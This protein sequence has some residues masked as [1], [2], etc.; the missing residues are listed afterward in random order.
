MAGKGVTRSGQANRRPTGPRTRAK[1]RAA[2]GLDSEELDRQETC[3]QQSGPQSENQ[4]EPSERTPELEAPRESNEVVEDQDPL[5]S[6]DQ[7]LESMRG[8]L[9]GLP[10]EDLQQV[11]S[12]VQ[13]QAIAAGKRPMEGIVEGQSPGGEGNGAPSMLQGGGSMVQGEK[14]RLRRLDYKLGRPPGSGPA[15]FYC[16]RRYSEPGISA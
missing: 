14:S 2:P 9:A 13:R 10:E 15:F 16:L 5:S 8:L 6:V 11:Y 7:Y 1:T 3:H 4:G 12:S